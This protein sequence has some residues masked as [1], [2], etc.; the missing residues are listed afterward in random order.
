MRRAISDRG[1]LQRIRQSLEK[2]DIDVGAISPETGPGQYEINVEFKSAVHAGDEAFLYKSTVKQAASED[3]LIA[4]FM[5]KPHTTWPGSSCHIHQSLW[6][7]DSGLPITWSPERPLSDAASSY[8]AGL[9]AGIV[10]FTA[11]FAPTVNSYKRLTP[12]SWA[13]TT[14]TWGLDNRTVSLRVVGNSPGQ[15]RI[16]HRLPGADVNPYLAIAACLASGVYGIE[17]KL[18]LESPYVG[19]AYADRRLAS[20]PRTL[21]D[22]LTVFEASDIARASFG[23]DFVDH[24]VTMKRWE[25][26]QQHLHVSEWEVRN[27]VDT[28]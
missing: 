2:A 8:L 15:R 23:D 14:A 6:N 18:E 27:Y 26:E 20:V 12:Y 21:A 25:T 28:A 7:A 16:E 11:L 1:A 10:E 19:D 24:F 22:A 4:T 5:A 3:G 13:G 9:L 17:H